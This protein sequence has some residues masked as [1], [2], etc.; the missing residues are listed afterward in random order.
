MDPYYYHH[1]NEMALYPF[2]SLF[3][4][5]Y[6]VLT[7]FHRGYYT[8]L[9][10]HSLNGQKSTL[11]SKF[12]KLNRKHGTFSRS[13]VTDYAKGHGE[14]DSGH[15]AWQSC[16]Q[17]A[18]GKREP[19]PNY[20]VPICDKI[21]PCINAPMGLLARTLSLQATSSYAKKLAFDWGLLTRASFGKGRGKA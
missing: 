2:F 4:T 17:Y 7:S 10:G 16:K 21:S 13:I 8:F 1:A 11:L 5:L 3:S 18:E 12:R 6:F 15:F 20:N 19:M 9:P 14:S